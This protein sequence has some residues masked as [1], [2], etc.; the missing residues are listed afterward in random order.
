MPEP[1]ISLTSADRS[2]QRQQ[3]EEVLVRARAKGEP[4]R[5]RIPV[6]LYDYEESRSYIPVREAA[7][8]LQLPSQDTT[9]EHLERLIYVLGQ[10]VVAIAEKGSEAVLEM[11]EGRG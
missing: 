9:P 3:I 6:H 4:L 10:C 5:V 2:T 11:L 7:W 1:Q 8:N